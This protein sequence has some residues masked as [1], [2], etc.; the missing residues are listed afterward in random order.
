MF[1]KQEKADAEGRSVSSGS[2]F[3]VIGDSV[4]YFSSRSLC[5]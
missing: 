2:E 4:R 5:E 1:Q 3:R